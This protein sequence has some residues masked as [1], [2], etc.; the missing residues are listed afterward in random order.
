M[1]SVYRIA[2]QAGCV[3]SS[4]RPDPPR[5][6]VTATALTQRRVRVKWWFTSVPSSCR[7]YFLHLAIDAYKDKESLTW[8]TRVP[9]TGMSGQSV[10]TYPSFFRSKPDVAFAAAEMRDGRRSEIAR[11]LIR[12]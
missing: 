6:G 8:V 1:P 7:P 9:F 12:R 5:P 4:S 10:L 2:P 3:G 11:V